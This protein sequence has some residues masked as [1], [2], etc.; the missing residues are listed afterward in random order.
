MAIV[1]IPIGAVIGAS[2][3][4]LTSLI[5]AYAFYFMAYIGFV[6]WFFYVIAYFSG[7]ETVEQCGWSFGF[8][9]GIIIGSLLL[10]L[11]VRLMIADSEVSRIISVLLGLGILWWWIVKNEIAME[12]T[13]VGLVFKSVVYVVFT[14]FAIFIACVPDDEEEEKNNHKRKK[15]SKQQ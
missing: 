1:T 13:A 4:M 3:A 2:L 12:S 14:L 6:G 8:C 5:F 10:A 15:K 7:W 11:I 9:L